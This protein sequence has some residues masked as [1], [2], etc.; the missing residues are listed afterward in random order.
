MFQG[1][2]KPSQ[3][4]HLLRSWASSPVRAPSQAQV[5]PQPLGRARDVGD[6][7]LVDD[8]ARGQHV[9]VVRDGKGEAHVLLDEQDRVYPFGGPA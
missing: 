2:G 1:L 7:P 9:D 8:A 6:R 3:R 5:L 4:V